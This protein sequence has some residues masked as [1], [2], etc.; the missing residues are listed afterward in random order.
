VVRTGVTVVVLIQVVGLVFT[1]S[2]FVQWGC[3]QACTVV[4]MYLV[5]A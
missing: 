3:V 5:E 4:V 1:S 2:D